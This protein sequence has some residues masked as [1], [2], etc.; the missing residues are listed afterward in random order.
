MGRSLRIR[1]DEV[2]VHGEKTVTCK[3]CKKRLKRRKR[4]YQTLNPMNKNSKGFLKT[5][6]EIYAELN[7]EVAK[8]QV[9][10]EIC[11]KCQE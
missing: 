5:R 3:V 2:Y 9:Q 7:V 11:Q 6:E 4:F 10:K 1:F 8:W